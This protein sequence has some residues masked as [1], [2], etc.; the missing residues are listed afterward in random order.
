MFPVDAKAVSFIRSS[1]R[2]LLEMESG[3]GTRSAAS[4]SRTSSKV[5]AASNT[6]RRG[7][8]TLPVVATEGSVDAV[9]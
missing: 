8:Q 6:L 2:S 4:F 5:W 1:L 7:G 3:T 9:G